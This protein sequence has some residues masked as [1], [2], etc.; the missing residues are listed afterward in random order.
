MVHFIK[1]YNYAQL[2]LDQFN[3]RKTRIFTNN[4]TLSNRLDEEA[5]ALRACLQKL[6]ENNQHMLDDVIKIVDHTIKNVRAERDKHVQSTEKVSHSISNTTES[7]A[8][9]NDSLVRRN[10]A[11][12]PTFFAYKPA[13]FERKTAYAMYRISITES[14]ENGLLAAIQLA[15]KKLGFKLGLWT[16]EIAP[17]NESIDHFLKWMNGLEPKKSE[18]QTYYESTLDTCNSSSCNP[19][20]IDNSSH[21]HYHNSY[22]DDSHHHGHD[23][24]HHGHDSHHHGHDS[25]HSA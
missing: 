13:S 5:T 22:N 15:F 7:C 12:T 25:H 11:V 23:S 8:R 3:Y 10:Y 20:V 9:C 19:P 18:G 24:H 2:F 1:K 21:H 17:E 6:A 14:T 16:P 4:I